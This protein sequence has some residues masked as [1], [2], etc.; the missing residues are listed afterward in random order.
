[1]IVPVEIR[2]DG[3]V[4]IEI[5]L[6]VNITKHSALSGDDDDWLLVLPV[7]HLRERMPDVRV[8]EL[9]KTVHA[10]RVEISRSTMPSKA[11]SSVE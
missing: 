1:M 9:G 11:M 4:G 2:P 7:A 3:C 6:A 8:I 5:F 10:A